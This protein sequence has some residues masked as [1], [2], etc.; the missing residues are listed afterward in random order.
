MAHF[1]ELNES[2]VVLRVIV[3]SNETCGEPDL[4][5]PD[6]CAAGQTFIADTL[7]LGGTWKQASYSGSFRGAYP[8]PGWIYDETL[9]VFTAPEAAD[10]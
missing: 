5:F 3:I 6:T 10:A 4:S 7:K 9:D 1:A 8:G 2:N